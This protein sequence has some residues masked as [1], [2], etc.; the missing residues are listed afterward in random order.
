MQCLWTWCCMVML[1]KFF[2]RHFFGWL[3]MIIWTYAILVILVVLCLFHLLVSL[4][5]PVVVFSRQNGFCCV[6]LF[7]LRVLESGYLLFY[8]WKE[9]WSGFV[10]S[11]SSPKKCLLKNFNS[12]TIQHQVHKHCK[13]YIYIKNSILLI[14]TNN[15]WTQWDLRRYKNNFI[16]FFS[17]LP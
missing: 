10:V 7:H 16:A 1:L 3:W 9:S 12:I 15:L 4:M 13:F 5:M 17:N 2:K 11:R 6:A 8:R 14:L